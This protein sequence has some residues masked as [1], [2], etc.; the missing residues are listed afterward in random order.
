MQKTLSGIFSFLKGFG[1]AI[2]DV[3]VLAGLSEEDKGQWFNDN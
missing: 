1:A 2:N 3:T